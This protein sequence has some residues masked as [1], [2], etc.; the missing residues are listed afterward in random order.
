MRTQ[1]IAWVAVTLLLSV[2]ACADGL[3]SQTAEDEPGTTTTAEVDTDGRKVAHWQFAG[4]EP[5]PEDREF[6]VQVAWIACTGGAK[7]QDPQPVVEYGEDIAILTVWAIPPE[8]NAH[9]CQ[10]N[11]PVTVTV[12]MTEPLGD[13]EVVPGP[14]K[15]Y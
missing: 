4:K 12:T 6:D 14:E 5:R 10:G 11:P 15:P 7:A 9:T 13:R 8:G 2:G 1:H 3:S